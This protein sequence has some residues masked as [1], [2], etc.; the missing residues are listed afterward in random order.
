MSD[1]AELEALI[2]DPREQMHVEVKAWLDLK[3]NEHKA[4][5]A[6]AI[7]A[8]AN[9]GGGFIIIG[10]T[11]HNGIYV[12]SPGRPANMGTYTDDAINAIVKSY[13]APHF[14]ASVHLVPQPGSQAT[15]PLIAIPG[16]HRVPI[17]AV[18]GSPDQRTLINGRVYTRRPGPES[19]EPGT[20]EE[21]R[22]IFARCLRA[23]RD[24]LLDAMRELLSGQLGGM[25]PKKSALEALLEFAE[26]GTKRWRNR[27]LH[28][29]RGQPQLSRGN[30]RLAY[31]IQSEFSY[32]TL[33]ELLEHL[34]VAE[35]RNTGWPEWAILNRDSLRPRVIEGGLE[36]FLSDAPNGVIEDPAYA[37]FWRAMPDGRLVLIRGFQE[38]S[39][40]RIR[41]GQ[42]FDVVL[43]IWR[44]GECFL[45]VRA[46][47][48]SL[49]VPR[50]DV[51]VAATYTG[52]AGRHLISLDGRRM[53]R[54]N[55]ICAQ[56]AVDLA[57]TVNADSIE[58]GL[59]EIVHGFLQPLYHSF[60]LFEP[61]P[62]MVAEE[63]RRLRARG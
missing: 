31:A 53:I 6:K 15:Y 36:A 2:R 22:D 5:L 57:M 24:D 45:H 28:E 3:T 16:Q 32:P 47:C 10:F 39:H 43:P 44:V 41:P 18:R 49:G 63:I 13:C 21:W 48:E 46:L 26:D 52:L 58:D 62:N 27:A 55:W 20:P 34:R 12:E 1:P 8:L 33:K 61:P 19:A 56:D 7:I 38:D 40:E 37:D 25:Q 4:V 59:P 50:S 11:R 17:Q 9:Y 29:V 60:D 35:R 54:D 14:H 23:N 30:Y 51:I 42:A